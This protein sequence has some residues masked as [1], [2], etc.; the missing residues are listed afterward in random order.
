MPVVH[1]I[2]AAGPGTAAQIGDPKEAYAFYP[3]RDFDVNEETNPIAA[4]KG[5]GNTA[6]PTFHFDL[7]IDH[8]LRQYFDN[9]TI[10]VGDILNIQIIPKK[11]IVSMFALE[12]IAPVT[13]NKFLTVS[14]CSFSSRT[15]LLNR[16]RTNLLI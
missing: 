12:V 6:S 15:I 2:Y 9:H 4:H 11:T 13:G 16:V 8:A 5:G 1:N 14:A 7:K 10:A 3:R